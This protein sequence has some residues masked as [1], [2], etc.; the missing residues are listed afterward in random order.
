MKRRKTIEASG[1]FSRLREHALFYTSR[2]A[3]PRQTTKVTSRQDASQGR[4]VGSVGLAVILAPMMAYCNERIATDD[5]DILTFSL[6]HLFCC[7][8]MLYRDALPALDQA[9]GRMLNGHVP[10]G[11]L[12][13]QQATWTH[14]QQVKRI[15]ERMEPLCHLL[16]RAA[17]GILDDLDRTSQPPES[18]PFVPHRQ[19][20][21]Y[22]IIEQEQ[23]LTALA[24]SLVTWQESHR[25]LTSFSSQFSQPLAA[26][27]PSLIQF[28]SAFAVMLEIAGAIFGDILLSFRTIPEQDD[29]VVA[30]LLFDLTQRSDQLLSMFHTVV[31]SLCLLMEAFAVIP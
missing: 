13:Y 8:D 17:E 14:L 29:E 6:H 21:H 19:P 4:A 12:D 27:S 26:F 1:R 18:Q 16:N 28:D 30:A 22:T 3:G 24:G 25:K 23:A 20:W 31:E 10:A 2:Q 7:F 15:L 5:M 11:P 9:T